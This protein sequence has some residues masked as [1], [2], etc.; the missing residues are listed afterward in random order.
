[1]SPSSVQKDT[2]VLRELYWKAG[3]PEYWL[4]RS[5]ELI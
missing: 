4:S 2:V 3:I 1:V 5:A